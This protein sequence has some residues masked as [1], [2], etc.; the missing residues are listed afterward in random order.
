M[1]LHIP[2][3]KTYA[4]RMILLGEAGTGKTSLF[5]WIK[6]KVLNYI[7]L[8]E[9]VV[10]SAAMT[11]VAELVVFYGYVCNLVDGVHVAL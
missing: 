7:N 4:L 2:I 9:S 8:S 1:A 3:A 10:T 11:T 6:Y 5:H